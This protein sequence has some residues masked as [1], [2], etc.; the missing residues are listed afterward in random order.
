MKIKKLNTFLASICLIAIF[1]TLPFMAACAAPAPGEPI[2]LKML[3]FLP[4]SYD[5]TWTAREFVDRVNARSQG[6]LTIDWIGGPE[7]IG[8]FDQ[9]E[10]V[11]NGSIDIVWHAGALYQDLVPVAAALPLSQHTPTEERKNG[12]YDW[13]VE[14]HKEQMNVMYLGRVITNAPH[15]L[16][17]NFPVQNPREDFKG[18]LIIGT[19]MHLPFL[20]AIGATN[21]SIPDP[22]TYTAMERGTAEGVAGSPRSAVSGSW[23]EVLK[24]WIDYELYWANNLTLLVNLDK[25]NTVPKNMQKLMQE[26]AEEVEGEMWASYGEL[27]SKARQTILDAGVQPIKFSEEDGKWLVDLAYSSM[28]EETKAKGT[29]NPDKLDKLWNYLKK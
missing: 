7:I 18:K 12:F 26:V 5:V 19:N 15:T 29:I 20:N 6:Q 9:G 1:T 13:L 3:T 27:N 25:W 8:Y 10:A 11:K 23:Q 17:T 22:E 21:V 14:V 16:W 28:W 24:Y 2:T 4:T